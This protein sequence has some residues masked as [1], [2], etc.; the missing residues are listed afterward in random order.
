MLMLLTWH[1]GIVMVYHPIVQGLGGPV[2]VFYSIAIHVN[3]LSQGSELEFL[4]TVVV[5]L[6]LVDVNCVDEL[7]PDFF[8]HALACLILSTEQSLH[9]RVLWENQCN[10]IFH[11]DRWEFKKHF[12]K[13][14][15]VKNYCLTHVISLMN[16]SST[17]STSTVGAPGPCQGRDSSREAFLRLFW[18][19]E[20]LPAAYWSHGDASCKRI[21][22]TARAS[23]SF[24]A[25]ASLKLLNDD[26]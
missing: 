2:I 14:S 16:W 10:G 6:L 26:L 25:T 21:P 18:V 22:T 23:L 5:L 7:L 9:N 11:L 8:P 4:S 20:G 1:R 19:W 3:V 12:L 24:E 17:T 15:L 13:F